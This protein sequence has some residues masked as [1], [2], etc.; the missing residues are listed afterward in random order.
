MEREGE[1]QAG[2]EERE[3]EVPAEDADRDFKYCA[4][5]A[6]GTEFEPVGEGD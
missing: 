5:V 6:G 3:Q 1:G 2:G 4:C